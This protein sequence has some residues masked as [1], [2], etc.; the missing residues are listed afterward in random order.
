MVLYA[1]D[2][3]KQYQLKCGQLALL[4][5]VHLAMF[6]ALCAPAGATVDL[7]VVEIICAKCDF[8]SLQMELACSANYYFKEPIK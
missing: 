4:F 8:V 7:V 1:H 2:L 6:P 3:V 5:C